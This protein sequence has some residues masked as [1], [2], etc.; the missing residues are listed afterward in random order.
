MRSIWLLILSTGV[1]LALTPGAV[2]ASSSRDHK[3]SEVANAE[4]QLQLAQQQAADLANAAAEEGANARAIA[5]LQSEAMRQTQ[6]NNAANAQ[7]LQQLA[8]TLAASIRSQGQANAANSVAILQLKADALIAKAD[9]K[10]ANAMAIGRADEIANAQAQSDA[11][12]QLAD[13]LT[14]DLAQLNSSNAQQIADA[15]ASQVEDQVAMEVQNDQALGANELFAADTILEAAN[16][17]VENVTIQGETKGDA[18][19]AHAEESLAN[20]EAML[21]ETP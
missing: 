10:L 20:A 9:A 3:L 18:M 17:E 12:H 8:T 11:L 4:A 2:F 19:I 6:L 15:Q 7:A 21:A 16:V 13:F 14:G 5:F 1:I